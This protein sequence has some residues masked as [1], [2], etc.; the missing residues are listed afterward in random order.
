MKENANAET[1]LRLSRDFQAPPERVFDA[2]LDAKTLKKIWSA[3][4]YTIVEMH[5]DARVG[6]EWR[7]AMRDE[8]SGS[9]SHCTARYEE[10]RRPARIVWRVKWLD[11]PLASAPEGRVTLEFAAAGG[12]TRLQLTHEFFPDRATRDAHAGG[13]SSGFDR[14]AKLLASEP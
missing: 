10:I 6:G 12:G 8:A 5:V 9:V 1:T 7:L 11:G 2:L 4:T 14:L 13:W 3:E